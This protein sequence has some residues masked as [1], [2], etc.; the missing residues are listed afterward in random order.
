[1]VQNVT[2][3]TIHLR[4]LFH[5]FETFD[6]LRRMIKSW[7]ENECLVS[8]FLIIAQVNVIFLRVDL[9]DR[10]MGFNLGPGVDLGRNS[11]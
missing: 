7:C 11:S 3:N 4:R 1:M 8:E 10:L 9:C 5:L 6:V 2:E